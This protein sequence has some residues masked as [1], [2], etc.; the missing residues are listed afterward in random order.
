[1]AARGKI[2]NIVQG[3]SEPQDF[4]IRNDGDALDGSGFTI[5]LSIYQDGQVP[6]SVP[7]VAWLSQAN[8][9]VRVSGVNVLSSGEYRVR[10]SLTDGSSKVGYVPNGPDADRWIVVTAYA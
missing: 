9:T 7:T 6:S 4:L 10:F 8:G 2:Y 3:T 1:M 5:G